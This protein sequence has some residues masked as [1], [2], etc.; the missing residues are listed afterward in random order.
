MKNLINKILASILILWLSTSFFFLERGNFTLPVMALYSSSEDNYKNIAFW[1]IIKTWEK[2]TSINIWSSLKIDLNKKS[3]IKIISNWFWE[4]LWWSS[5][6]NSLFDFKLKINKGISLNINNSSIFIKRK[7]A[8]VN[9]VWIKWVSLLKIKWKDFY[10][11]PW[12][13]VTFDYKDFEKHENL[14]STI[15][16]LNYKKTVIVSKE[17]KNLTAYL[18]KFNSFDRKIDDNFLLFFDKKKNE[19]SYKNKMFLFKKCTD[20]MWEYLEKKSEIKDIK[21][22][23]FEPEILNDKYLNWLLQKNINLIDNIVEK[24][25]IDSFYKTKLKRTFSLFNYLKYLEKWLSEW[26]LEFSKVILSDIK[27]DLNNYPNKDKIAIFFIWYNSLMNEY[28]SILPTE[29]L[30]LRWNIENSIFRSFDNDFAMAE[31]ISNLHFDFISYLLDERAYLLLDVFFSKKVDIFYFSDLEIFKELSNNFSSRMITLSKSYSKIQLLEHWSAVSWEELEKK[32]KKEENEEKKI[33]DFIESLDDYVEPRIFDN[34]RNKDLSDFLWKEW[35]KVSENNIKWYMNWGSLF[36]L[37]SVNYK[38]IIFDANFNYKDETFY[39]IVF[40]KRNNWQKSIKA[41]SFVLSEFWK[42][43]ELPAKETDFDNN[44]VEIFP[45][46][47]RENISYWSVL[48]KEMLRVYLK[49]NWIHIFSK[50]VKEYAK[51]LY[52]IEKALVENDDVNWKNIKIEFDIVLNKWNVSKL[53]LKDYP[54]QKMPDSNINWK[55]I[56]KVATKVF[57]IVKTRNENKKSI[58]EKFNK[59][60]FKDG[61]IKKIDDL[62]TDWF[63]FESTM[64]LSSWLFTIKWNYYKEKDLFSDVSAAANSRTKYYSNISYNTLLKKLDSFN[65]EIVKKKEKVEEKIIK[66]EKEAETI[67]YTDVPDEVI[68]WDWINDL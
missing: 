25:E 9:I 40:H 19:M 60:S 47:E 17:S 57:E 53:K 38:W 29:T 27:K 67:D 63:Y 18:N 12:Y 3:S 31:Y 16:L 55:S 4:F 7:W 49:N 51:D 65:S 45:E 68:N 34:F 42:I 8:N 35:F 33:K 44:P 56:K 43:L 14:L 23:C 28:S 15:K 39:S 59:F 10:I 30:F 1:D 66:V 2:S 13:W 37:T 54:E 58:I 50:D 32:S 46:I 11:T 52:K 20:I 21:E 36:K 6:I 5:F 41:G 26:N 61:V 62:K 48:K 64:R 22:V 24:Y